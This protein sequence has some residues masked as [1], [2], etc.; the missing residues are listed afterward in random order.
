[1]E[2]QSQDL[3]KE[4][5]KE[6]LNQCAPQSWAALAKPRDRALNPRALM[7]LSARAPL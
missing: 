5:V 7:E 6:G 2:G 3:E 1:M 4:G